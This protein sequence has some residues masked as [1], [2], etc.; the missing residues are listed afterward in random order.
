M[1]KKITLSIIVALV[2][3]LLVSGIAFANEENPNSEHKRGRRAYGE[4]V[5]VGDETFTVQN[6]KGDEITFSIDANTNFRSPGEDEVTFADLEVGKKVAVAA[7]EDSVAKLVIL[8]PDDFQPGDRFNVRK[9]GEIT[10]VDVDAGTFSL[11]TP[12]GEELTF[13]VGENTI[14]KG[15][16]ESLD[17]MQVGWEAGVAAKEQ[18]DGTLLVALVIAGNRSAQ[19]PPVQN[20]HTP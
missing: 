10:S 4:V 1:S 2:L 14:Y 3:T 9:R 8:L 15:Q 13:T 16:L 19:R 7:G 6:P 11:Q 17:E 18:E 5:S 20:P 12:N